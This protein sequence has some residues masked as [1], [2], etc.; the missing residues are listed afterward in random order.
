MPERK[1]V[2]VKVASEAKERW[3]E[4]AD[5]SME[6]NS[7]SD[8]IRLSVEKEINGQREGSDSG[9]EH[10]E[11]I[12]KTLKQIQT[13]IGK[14]DSRLERVEHTT[15]E[16][17]EISRLANNV[18]SLLPDEKP[19]SK[20]WEAKR[21][22]IQALEHNEGERS[23]EEFKAGWEGTPSALAEVFEVTEL[24]MRKALEKL[25]SDMSGRVRTTDHNGVERYW[26][27]V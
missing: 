17:P 24:D 12:S 14:L 19:G 9:S 25:A 15:Q 21:R 1:Q 22:E 26:R 23:P 6:V 16:D 27:D 4:Y 10:L 3:Q 13:E 7:M 11:D 2:N 5:E 18:F 8:L 20:K